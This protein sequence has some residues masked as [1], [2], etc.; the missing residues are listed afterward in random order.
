[1]PTIRNESTIAD[2]QLARI[3]TPLDVPRNG[4]IYRQSERADCIYYVDHGLVRVDFAAP[5]G[6]HAIVAVLGPGSFLGEACLDSRERWRSNASALLDT[7][8]I[9]VAKER[10]LRLL[11]NDSSFAGQFISY[12]VRRLARAEE[13]LADLQLHSIEKRLARALLLLADITDENGLQTALAAINQQILAEIVGTTRPRVS[14]FLGKFRRQG[15]ISGRTQLRV[16]SSL[17][18]V[19]LNT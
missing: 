5:D 12:L 3:G 1:M 19:L 16:H 18:R 9:A 10:L 13:D 17:A 4:T 14:H 11:R 8:L 2:G 15:H 7:R 6:R